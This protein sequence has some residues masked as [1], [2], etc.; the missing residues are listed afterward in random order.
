MLHGISQFLSVCSLSTIHPTHSNHLPSPHPLHTHTLTV[1][2][3]HS[4]SHTHPHTH[5]LSLSHT[6]THT[7]THYPSLQLRHCMSCGL[8]GNIW[9]CLVCAHT[10]CGRYAMRHAEQHYR[11][12]QHSFSLELATGRCNMMYRRNSKYHFISQLKMI[13]IIAFIKI[14]NFYN[15][16]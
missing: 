4:L 13:V 6:H 11:E 14:Y 5:P 7:H 2:L 12:T 8:T 1:T 3:T 15:I 9:A 10:G 16:F